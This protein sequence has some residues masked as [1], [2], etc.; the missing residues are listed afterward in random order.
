VSK[1][2][3]LPEA[4]EDTQ[5]LRLFLADKPKGVIERAGQALQEGAKRLADFPEIGFPM[6]DGT[7]RRELFLPFGSGG[8]ILRYITDKHAVFIIRAWHSKENR[9]DN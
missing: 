1:I 7:D 4:L 3:W 9:D 8:Y 2:I 6:N 5:R